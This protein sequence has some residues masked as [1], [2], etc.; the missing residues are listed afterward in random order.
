MMAPKKILIFY[1]SIGSG[2][3][4]AARSIA[5]AIHELDSN[6]EVKLADIFR[7]SQRNVFFQELLAFFP[8]YLF[9]D[10]YT[11]FWKN[12]SIKWLYNFFCKVGPVKYSI[13]K[14]ME[15][16]SPDVVACTHSYPCTVVA[17]WKIKNRGLPLVAVPTDL[18]VHP[19]WPCENV[20]AFIT[21]TEIMKKEM[22]KRGYLQKRIYSFGIPVSPDVSRMK[23]S[24]KMH[25]KVNAL[26][27]AGSYRV[28]PYMTIRTRVKE[29]ID[30]VFTYP[31]PNISWHF[32]FG[33]A[34]K[35]KNIAK[36]KLNHYKNL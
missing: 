23:R 15:I 17:N 5:Q 1:A 19:Y 4:V 32:V 12:G 11:H 2:H 28:A 21:P 3:L 8:N 13:R 29:M 33:A 27:L 30:Y 6:V 31:T 35:L 20:D 22:V 9:P 26:V 34:T 24:Y 18:F 25:Q 36:K 14:M 16:Y 7:Y 10:L